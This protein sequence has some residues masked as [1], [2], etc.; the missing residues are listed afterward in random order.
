MKY[1]VN[2]PFVVH[3]SRNYL[4][5]AENESEAKDM[6][7]FHIDNNYPDVNDRGIMFHYDMD[8][9]YEDSTVREYNESEYNDEFVI[10]DNDG[11]EV[12]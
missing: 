1:I 12:V 8:G 3:M 5:E 2:I 11:Y 7:I 10:I 4:I 9:V 6:A